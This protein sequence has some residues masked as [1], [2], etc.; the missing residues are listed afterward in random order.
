MSNTPGS[1]RKPGD[2]SWV[3][4]FWSIVVYPGIGQWMQ[5][6]RNAGTFYAAVF[7]VLAFFFTWIL[8][9]YLLHVVPILRDALQG[10]P[11][12]GREIPPLRAIVQPFGAVLFVY[13]GN[14][15]DVLRGR[16]QLIRA[17]APTT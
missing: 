2:P 3:P 17:A 7:T 9:T 8:I 14:V 15:I 11:L 1:K 4:V 5:N 12:E 10:L 6:R 13:I 16:L